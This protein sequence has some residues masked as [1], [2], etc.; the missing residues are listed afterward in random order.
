MVNK[1]I[2]DNGVRIISEYMP[3]VHSVSI[4]IWVA[5]GSRHERREHNGV[6]HFIEHLMFKGTEQRSAL[7]IAREIDSVGGV[8]NAFTSREYVCYYAKVLDKFLPK[9]I[10]LLADIF[11]NSVFDSE[12]I[13]K[14]RKVILQEINMLEDTPDDYVHDLF[15]RSFWRGHPLG[16]SI[17]GS[18][19]SI[20]GLSRDAIITHLREKY[21]SDDIIIAVAGNVRHDELLSLVDGL[22]GQ[23]PTGSGRDICHLPAYEKQV[24]V[25]EKDLEQV[26]ICLGTK[27]FPQ[28]HPRRF[29]VY[30]V[31][32]LLGG[33]MS[34]RLF[35]EIRERLG[36]AYSVYSYVVSHT[37]AG[38]L[39][40]Y[41][42]TSPAK[43]DDVLDIAFAELKRLKTELVPFTELESAK[44]Q[45]KG[46]IY[47][48]LESSDN[49]MTKLAKN[50]IYFGRYIP[51]HELTDGFDSVTSQGVLE[52]AGEIFDERYLTLALMGKVDSAA[53]DVSRLAL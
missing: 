40:V 4:G 51:I 5:N 45:I 9:T 11:L 22:F 7:D 52:L 33:S 41:A 39:V 38:S 8:L 27:A 10:D 16:L 2:L 21:R 15:H 26:H 44:E 3:H 6:A 47:L 37:D 46:N 17:L 18:V 13:E 32:T 20:E 53:F 24:E 49:R 19:E 28:N 35:Q 34:S 1:T 14:E 31:N 23:V 42:G 12:E 48:S 29:E 50:E 30:L 36:L 25:V 43:L